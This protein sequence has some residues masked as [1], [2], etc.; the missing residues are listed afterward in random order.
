MNNFKIKISV[1]R[2]KKT[3]KEFQLANF[4]EDLGDKYGQKYFITEIG[5]VVHINQLDKNT[6]PLPMQEIES[7][8]DAEIK[9]THNKSTVSIGELWRY[10]ADKS[11]NGFYWYLQAMA[12]HESCYFPEDYFCAE[13]IDTEYTNSIPQ[14]LFFSRWNNLSLSQ[15][16]KIVKQYFDNPV[17]YN[18]PILIDPYDKV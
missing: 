1:K 13:T 7:I 17:K 9:K 14:T 11:P 3:G 12:F 18:H 5:E 4:A 8:Y 2:C 10:L 6:V 15:K 16:K